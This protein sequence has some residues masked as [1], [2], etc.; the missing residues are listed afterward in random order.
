[1]LHVA[2]Q[3][4]KEHSQLTD[5]RTHC[6]SDL[7]SSQVTAQFIFAAKLAP[8]SH[9]AAWQHS[10]Y[11]LELGHLCNHA[12][13]LCDITRLL[14]CVYNHSTQ[15]HTGQHHRDAEAGRFMLAGFDC[16][17]HGSPPRACSDC[18]PAVPSGQN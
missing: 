4:C 17:A 9:V 16:S 18:E 6:L 10:S 11:R 1:M 13:M 15:Q 14:L 2:G 7:A 3:S 5:A 8:P 12:D